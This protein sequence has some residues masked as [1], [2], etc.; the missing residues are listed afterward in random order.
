MFEVSAGSNTFYLVGT[1]SSAAITM[2]VWDLQLNCMFFA[3]S[4]GTVTPTMVTGPDAD[5]FS[6]SVPTVPV[7]TVGDLAAEKAESEAFARDRVD[8]ELTAMRRQLESLQREVTRMNAVA[9]TR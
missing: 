9:N 1:K 3:T 7:P 2:R 5:Q 6:G 4:Y 8:R